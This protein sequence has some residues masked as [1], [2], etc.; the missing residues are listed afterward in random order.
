MDPKM[1]TMFIES[2][3]R[4]F[5]DAEL[6][7]A[8]YYTGK[9]HGAEAVSTPSA[10][11]C[12]I[13]VLARAR[14]GAPLCF[15]ADSIGCGGGRRY[16]G[17]TE[18]ISPTFEY[19]LS[20]GLPGKFEG[21]R[22]KKTPEIVREMMKIAPKFKAPA[23]YIVFKR[24]DLLEESD[25]PDAVVFLRPRTFSPGCSRSPIS[26]RSS[27]TASSAPF[28]PGAVPSSSIRISKKARTARAP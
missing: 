8:F 23:P 22:Y 15:A 11:Q 14:K 13:G 19:F 24:F 7:L 5:N 4:H 25:E 27:R 12:M 18:E 3:K 21:E 20:R 17:F 9:P 2:W 6:P 28:Q 1:K 16:S 10:H 26:T